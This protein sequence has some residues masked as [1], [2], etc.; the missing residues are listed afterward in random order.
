MLQTQPE[1]QMRVGQIPQGPLPVELPLA[2]PLR[3]RSEIRKRNRQLLRHSPQDLELG[4]RREPRLAH[5]RSDI[6]RLAR[7]AHELTEAREDLVQ[8]NQDMLNEIA[9]VEKENVEL[10]SEIESIRQ[11]LNLKRHGSDEISQKLR[12]I[13]L[14]EG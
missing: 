13:H 5:L 4:S 10:R 7:E 12:G 11:A 1:E 3:L 9:A 2:E 6:E 14:P 8:K